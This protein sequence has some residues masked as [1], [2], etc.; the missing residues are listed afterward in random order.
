MVYALQRTSEDADF[1]TEAVGVVDEQA[2]KTDAATGFGSSESLDPW[3]Q[4]EQA[5]LAED[6]HQGRTPVC[7]RCGGWVQ[8]TIDGAA[9][10]LRKP[11]R[12]ECGDCGREGEAFGGP[13]N[14]GRRITLEEGGHLEVDRRAARALVCPIC[15]ASMRLLRDEL[16][17]G[18]EIFAYDCVACGASYYEAGGVL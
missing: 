4:E 3:T 7:P 5:A 11:V 15:H 14:E 13:N 10:T 8:G 18:A 9:T 1:G 6:V 17:S 16:P 12:L 2:T